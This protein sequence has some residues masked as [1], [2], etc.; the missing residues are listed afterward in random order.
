LLWNVSLYSFNYAGA[1]EK[2]KVSVEY[3][4]GI[5]HGE[6]AFEKSPHHVY[7]GL[8]SD[9]EDEDMDLEG[10]RKGPVA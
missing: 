10:F 5:D 2:K 9:A 1:L 8:P 7:F 3:V 6:D 4:G